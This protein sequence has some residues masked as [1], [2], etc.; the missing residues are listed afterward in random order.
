MINNTEKF[1]TFDDLKEIESLKNDLNKINNQDLINLFNENINTKWK[2]TELKEK[3]KWWD[4]QLSNELSHIN[5]FENKNI[6]EEIRNLINIINEMEF[7]IDL[8]EKL[9]DSNIK[10]KFDDINNRF[11]IS[12]SKNNKEM[13]VNINSTSWVVEI[14]DL[15]HDIKRELNYDPIVSD[16]RDAIINGIINFFNNFVEPYDKTDPY[17]EATDISKVI[18]KT[19]ETQEIKNLTEDLKALEPFIND[20]VE[21]RNMLNNMP[22]KVVAVLWLKYE[23]L[24]NTKPEDFNKL[25]KND[26]IKTF[27][28]RLEENK[29]IFEKKIENFAN[30]I[31]DELMNLQVREP[32]TISYKYHDSERWALVFDE[33]WWGTWNLELSIDDSWNFELRSTLYQNYVNK[34]STSFDTKEIAKIIKEFWDKIFNEYQ[35]DN[36]KN[37]SW[38]SVTDWF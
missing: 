8:K 7:M 33:K 5:I 29:D 4:Q 11:V 3:L 15:H 14:W 6:V 26:K 18:E 12:D 25:E 1:E 2:I 20:K 30:E 32:L 34:F 27:I 23:N 36:N 24:L 22:D 28:N 10:I 17:G 19:I 13:Y 9:S 31:N 38:E 21:F 35:Q 16:N 37:D